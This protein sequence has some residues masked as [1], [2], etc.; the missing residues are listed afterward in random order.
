MV[1]LLT[2]KPGSIIHRYA[3]YNRSLISNN[4]TRVVILRSI[5]LNKINIVTDSAVCLPDELIDRYG[6]RIVPEIIMFGNKEYRDRVDLEAKEFYKLLECEKEIPT[7]SA[8]SPQD[9]LDAFQQAAEET[10]GIVCIL[11]TAGFSSMGMASA[12][13]AKEIFNKV[14]VELIDSRTAV[15]AYGFIVLAAAKTAAEG[16]SIQEVVK[17]AE[18][19]RNRVNMIATLNTVKYLAKGGRI[20][21][22]A[23]WASTILDIKPIIQVPTTTGVLEPVERVVT[24]KRALTRLVEIIEETAGSGKPVHISIDHANVPED[25]VWLKDQLIN[26]LNCIEILVNDWAPVAGAHCGPGV[27]GCSYYIDE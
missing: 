22:A 12:M 23:H 4:Y 2:K 3:R 26:H 15:G 24:R 8:P 16:K 10:S 25:V 14:P 18:D 11:V 21:K 27:I 5:D 1:S 17:A 9:F 20:G 6:I 19:M 13:K 7:T